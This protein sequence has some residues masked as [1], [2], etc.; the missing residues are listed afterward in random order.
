MPAARGAHEAA[1][2]HAAC[3]ICVWCFVTGVCCVGPPL[4]LNLK[5]RN[6]HRPAVNLKTRCGIG[7]PSHLK[8]RCGIGPPSH[9]KTRCGIGPP[10]HLKTR[11]GIGPPSI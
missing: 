5:T 8:T 2:A 11:C 9:L 1:A 4:H 3:L 10:S 6:L 7:P